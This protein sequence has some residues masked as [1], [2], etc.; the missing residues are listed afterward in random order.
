M[1]RREIRDSAMKLLF[2]KSLRDDPMEALYAL[3]EDIDEIIVIGEVR[4]KISHADANAMADKRLVASEGGEVSAL[5]WMKDAIDF[6]IDSYDKAMAQVQDK[7]PQVI[8]IT[9]DDVR[10]TAELMKNSNPGNYGRRGPNHR[11]RR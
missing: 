5:T 10:T 3:A 11:R 8:F 7:K 6:F 2:E 4:N 9:S 1:T